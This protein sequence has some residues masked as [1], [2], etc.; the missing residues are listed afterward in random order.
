MNRPLRILFVTSELSPLVSTGGLAEVAAALPRALQRRGHEVRIALPFYR[1][2]PGEYRN[3]HPWFCGAELGAGAEYGALHQGTLPGSDLPL[4]LVEHE[5]YFGRDAMYGVGAYEYEDNA[6][7][8]CFFCL[9]ILNGLAAEGWK[10]D[11]VH[12]NDWHAAPLIIYLKTRYHQDPFWKDTAC[13]FTIHNLAYQ[14]RFAAAHFD[15]TGFDRNLFSF[16]YLEYEGDLNMMKGG[17]VFADKI[18]TVSPRYAREIQTVEYGAGLHGVLTARQADLSGILNGVDYAAWHPSTDT[19]IAAR[20][21]RTD[22]SGKAVC[23]RALQDLFGLPPRDVPLFG[24]VSRLYPEKGM[25]ILV[26]ALPALM[27]SE[28]QLV[29]L[30]TGHPDIEA[31]IRAA[32]AA[33]PDRI[34]AFLG[35]D[36]DR[37]HAVYAGSDFFL[38]PSRFEPCGL[39]QLYAMTYGTLPLVRRTGGL[40]DTVLPYRPYGNSG[41]AA[42]GFS[43][44]PQTA[45]ALARCICSALELYQD[46]P[47]MRQLR[48][49]AMARDYSW[50]RSSAA[51]V[52]LYESIVNRETADG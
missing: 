28:M 6:E 49:N 31:G 30:G 24:V 8:F 10:P 46:A 42:T 11:V 37:A 3:S 36:A 43:F 22:L 19:R 16:N 4:Y 32:A 39:G 21:D 18:T 45:P 9:A 35:F 38:M 15:R 52:A 17:I 50:D 47:R 1:Q 13:L 26:D 48:D 33:H 20:Y 51:Y 23:K 5:A 27:Q 14:G 7:R 2:V 25:D 12:C 29:V 41:T 40:A 34:G 44:V